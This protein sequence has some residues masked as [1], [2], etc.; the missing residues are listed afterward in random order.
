MEKR[1]YPATRDPM[2]LDCFIANFMEDYEDCDT[3]QTWQDWEA[4]PAGG[5]D[6]HRSAAV[7]Y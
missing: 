1:R 3:M 7:G 2:D 6:P 4:L 5:Q